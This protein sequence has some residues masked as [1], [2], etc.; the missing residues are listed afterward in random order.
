[1][2]KTILILEDLTGLVL[3]IF[4]GLVLIIAI[5]FAARLFLKKYK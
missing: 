3:Q 2:D 1:M 5:Y 4:G